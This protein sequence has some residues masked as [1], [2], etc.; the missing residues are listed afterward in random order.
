[1]LSIGEDAIHSS[2]PWRGANLGRPG[3]RAASA[4]CSAQ[5]A[6]VPLP[7]TLAAASA[8]SVIS[9]FFL[10][11][12]YLNLESF[13]LPDLLSLCFLST[14]LSL[15]SISNLKKFLLSLLS[16]FSW[17]LSSTLQTHHP[18]IFYIILSSESLLPQVCCVATFPSFKTFFPFNFPF[19]YY[20]NLSHKQP[21]FFFQLRLSDCHFPWRTHSKIYITWYLLSSQKGVFMVKKK[22]HW[23]NKSSTQS[24]FRK[25]VFLQNS[26]VF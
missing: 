26:S 21:Q 20:K 24:L 6:S 14:P 17:F 5:I 22:V 9:P 12:H 19:S 2:C 16:V 1:M 25:P 8:P 4:T 11:T 23:S 13:S 7:Q 15:S 10:P 3:L 18:L